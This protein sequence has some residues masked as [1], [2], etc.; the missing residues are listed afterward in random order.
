MTVFLLGL[1]LIV[2]FE[3]DGSFS[4]EDLLVANIPFSDSNKASVK[5]LL[6]IFSI[7]IINSLVVQ[8]HINPFRDLLQVQ[9]FTQ[10]Q[11]L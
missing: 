8:A 10:H 11:N 7:Q 5:C 9:L 6:N 2:T 3:L 1:E 4:E